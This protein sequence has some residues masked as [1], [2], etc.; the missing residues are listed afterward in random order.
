MSNAIT[1]EYGGR[2]LVIETEAKVSMAYDANRM[3]GAPHPPYEACRAVWDTGAMSTVITPT[4]ARKLEL[5]SLGLVQMQHANGVSLVNTYMI[6][7]LLPNRIEIKTIYVME[8]SMTDTDILIGMD[9]ITL[10]DFAITNKDGKTVF[11]FD[12]PSTR[13]TDYTEPNC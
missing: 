11:S 6:N 8:G 12:V 3:V 13:R 9:I 4:L 5:Q 7:L 10:C 1:V 2:C